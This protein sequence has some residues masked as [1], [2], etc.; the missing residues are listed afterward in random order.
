MPTCLCIGIYFIIWFEGAGLNV[1][2]LTPQI[3]WGLFGQDLFIGISLLARWSLSSAA[4]LWRD[5]PAGTEGASHSHI[6]T[7]AK[8]G[9]VD[10]CQVT[11]CFSAVDA[12]RGLTAL[13]AL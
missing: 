5:A 4:S 7:H 6:F 13:Q 9:W 2:T 10:A 8:H 3:L 12:L 1:N 11:S